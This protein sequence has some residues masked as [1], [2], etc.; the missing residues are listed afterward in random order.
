MATTI[1]L[2]DEQKSEIIALILEA[3]R[4]QTNSI[5]YSDSAFSAP[6][7]DTEQQKYTVAVIKD[8]GL[9]SEEAGALN[10][11]DLFEAFG[12]EVILLNQ[13]STENLEILEGY[14]NTAQTAANTAT[15][16]ATAASNSAS[17]AATSETNAI[18][19]KE[20]AEE[21]KADAEAAAAAAE[22]A[23]EEAKLIA[24]ATGAVSSIIGVNLTANRVLV[25]DGNGKVA[26]SSITTTLLNYLSGLTGNVQTQINSKLNSSALTL[27]NASY[28]AL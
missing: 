16:K 19:A 1:T 13:E 5:N 4:G 15:S 17:Q 25:S 7:T 26:I 10:L 9:T 21:A 22:A 27:K 6:E 18:N 3:F 12:A 28:T 8:L 14:K 2:T 24:G 20:S 11:R 23:K